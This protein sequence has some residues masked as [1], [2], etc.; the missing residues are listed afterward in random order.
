MYIIYCVYTARSSMQIMVYLNIKVNVS[1]R[2]QHCLLQ[3]YSLSYMWGLALFTIMMFTQLYVRVG[4]VYYND[5]HS[6]ICEGWHCLLQRC[7][8]SYMWGLALFT[9]M[10]LTQLYVRVGI[11]YY[12]DAHSVICE[13]WHFTHMCKLLAWPHHFTKRVVLGP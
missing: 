3:R 6:V 1:I 9:T 5:V 2:T 11:V 13:G 7:S 8:L 12:N 4:I 10:M